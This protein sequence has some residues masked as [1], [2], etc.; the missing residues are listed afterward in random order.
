VGIGSG[1]PQ[2]AASQKHGSSRGGSGGSSGVDV[3]A[4]MHVSPPEVLAVL[5]EPVNQ[6]IITA[7][8]DGSIKVRRHLHQLPWSV[9]NSI[10]CRHMCVHVI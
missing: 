8:N 7:G 1:K 2:S 4:A 5:F 9:G 10:A 3:L 6:V